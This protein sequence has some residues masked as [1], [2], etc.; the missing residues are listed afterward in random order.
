MALE[1]YRLHE[2][3]DRADAKDCTSQAHEL[4]DEVR[5]D[6]REWVEL[7]VIEEAYHDKPLISVFLQHV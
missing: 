2:H 1:L 7:A 3:L 4:I 5:L 6:L